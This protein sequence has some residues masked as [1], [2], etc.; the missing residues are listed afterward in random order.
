MENYAD[1]IDT[2]ARMSILKVKAAQTCSVHPDVLIRSEN[3]DA[4]RRAVT[5]AQNT[6]KYHDKAFLINNVTNAVQRELDLAETTCQQCS[7][8]MF[9]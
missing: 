1:Y 4:C 8:N 9:P 7:P 2:L 3:S 5:V 6:L